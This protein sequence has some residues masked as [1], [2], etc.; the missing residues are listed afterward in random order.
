M[1]E[2]TGKRDYSMFEADLSGSVLNMHLLGRLLKWLKPYKFSLFVS[3]ILVLISSTLQIMMPIIIS[4][5][6]IDHIIR[7][8]SDA[9]T[10]DFGL[11]EL[12]TYL[13]DS[14]GLPPL[15]VACVLYGATSSGTSK[16][17]RHHFT[18]ALRLDG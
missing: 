14:F 13:A 5:V 9:D 1:A 3:S 11:I 18:T 6:A 15:I 16:R 7:G 10:P 8:E 4:L 17:A 12:N 2:T